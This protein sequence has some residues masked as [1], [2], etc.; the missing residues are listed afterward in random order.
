MNYC[1]PSIH[2]LRTTLDWLHWL[3][4][5]FL[6]IGLCYLI[7]F[8]FGRIVLFFVGSFVAA[9]FVL[10][11]AL[12]KGV[13]LPL[14]RGVQC[15]SCQEWKLVHVGCISFGYRFY[16]CDHC[17]QRCKRQ[18]HDSPWVDASGE[19]DADMYKPVP[20]FG[21]SRKREASICAWKAAGSIAV[22]FLFPLL[23]GLL[24]GVRG[25]VSGSV[26]G[27]M[28]LFSVNQTSEKKILRTRPVLWDQE[29]DGEAS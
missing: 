1:E 17:G 20:F 16:R 10:S 26:I 25:S 7:S 19:R 5:L 23:G 22:L 6:M 15:P 27:V 11:R 24:G 14:F 9:V 3:C 21:P 29:I 13:L 4:L 8:E 18:D 28:V 12:Y 2:R